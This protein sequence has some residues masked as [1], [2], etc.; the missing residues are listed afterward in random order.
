MRKCMEMGKCGYVLGAT[1]PQVAQ[2]SGC[3]KGS[4]ELKT[5]EEVVVECIDSLQK[6]RIETAGLGSPK[7]LDLG[8]RETSY[9]CSH[10]PP[11]VF[12]P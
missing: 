3:D 2:N 6:V 8:K 10:Q 5:K 12:S 7:T 1:I 4:Y 9:K 11:P